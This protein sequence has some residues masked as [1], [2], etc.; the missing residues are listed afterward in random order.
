MSVRYRR[1]TLFLLTVILQVTHTGIFSASIKFTEDIDVFWLNDPDND[2]DGVQIGFTSPF[3][4]LS[5]SHKRAKINQTQP[6][7]ITNQTAFSEF[8]KFMITSDAFSWRL[9]SKNLRV[10]ALKFPVDKGI[11]FNKRVDLKGKLRNTLL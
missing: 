9:S 7:T 6:F 1:A 11:S 10:Q 4:E 5:A 3:S 8:T 2:P